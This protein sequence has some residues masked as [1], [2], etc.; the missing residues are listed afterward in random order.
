MN[1]IWLTLKKATKH[2]ILVQSNKYQAINEDKYLG[3][4]AKINIMPPIIV[5]A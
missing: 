4:F 5:V 3:Y 2:V 1:I